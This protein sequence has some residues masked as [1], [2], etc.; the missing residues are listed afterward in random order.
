MASSGNE[1]QVDPTGAGHR[2]VWEMTWAPT[3]KPPSS[4]ARTTAWQTARDLAARG[5]AR[6]RQPSAHPP[7]L[8][9]TD[10]L[11]C[12]QRCREASQR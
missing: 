7:A 9:L 6:H 2:R 1:Y 4:T 8:D 5:H 11:E 3:G 10:Y 12:P